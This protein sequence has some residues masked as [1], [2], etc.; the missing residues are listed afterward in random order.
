M[1]ALAFDRDRDLVGRRHQRTLAKAK[2]ADWG[3]RPIVHAIDLLDAELVEEPVIDHR[4]RARAA[5]LG[6]LEDDDGVPR[7]V[8]CRRQALRRAEQHRGVPVVSAGV[9]LARGL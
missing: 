8:A 1:A 3:A 5:F 9:H 2:G 7:E 4:H 6:G